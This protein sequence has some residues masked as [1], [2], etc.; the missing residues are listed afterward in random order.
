MRWMEGDLFFAHVSKYLFKEFKNSLKKQQN[1][2][3]VVC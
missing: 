3:Y 2:T 1:Q